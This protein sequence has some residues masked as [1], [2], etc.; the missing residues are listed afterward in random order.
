MLRDAAVLKDLCATDYAES[1]CYGLLLRV[2]KEQAV[3]NEDGS[4]RLRTKEDGGMDSSILQNLA[5]PD[6]TYREKAGKQH[7]ATPQTLLRPV[8]KTGQH[9]DRLPV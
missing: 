5:D 8:V 4:Y 6:A 3:Q 1:V 7:R 9:C 2:L